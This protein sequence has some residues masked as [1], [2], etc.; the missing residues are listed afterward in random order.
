MSPHN[1]TATLERQNLPILQIAL[2][3][4]SLV[5]CAVGIVSSIAQ[6]TPDNSAEERK[7]ESTIPEHVPLKVKIKN[8]QSFKD[9]KNKNWAREL[10]IEIKNT[11][12]KPIYFMYMVIFLPDM[13][14][15][16]NPSGFQVTFGRK[17][18]FRVTTPVQPD[19]VPIL[20][21]ESITLK[22]PGSQVSSY[23]KLRDE[24]KRPDP[25]KVEFDLQLIN[26][27]DG[28]G[29]RGTDGH[30]FPARRKP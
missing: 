20:P 24:E 27:G 26:F 2:L 5:V 1:V 30:L 16:G 23:E 13:I 12:N 11:G 15:N 10:E 9:M 19:D 8:E 6:S 17:D 28:S 21:G 29:L 14:V 4:S 7:F 22:I 25:K 18:L 3:A